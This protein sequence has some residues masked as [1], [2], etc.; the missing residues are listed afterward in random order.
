M[1][2]V[3]CSEPKLSNGEG[4]L[5]RGA[6]MSAALPSEM[7]IATGRGLCRAERAEGTKQGKQGKS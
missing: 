5:V 4:V 3:P 7:L 6:A 2:A 1:S